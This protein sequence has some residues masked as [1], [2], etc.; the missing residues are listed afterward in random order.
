ME[1]SRTKPLLID[2]ES[3]YVSDDCLNWVSQKHI[4]TSSHK[5]VLP[6][7][8]SKTS[9]PRF[10]Q[11]YALILILTFQSIEAFSSYFVSKHKHQS[12]NI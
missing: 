6:S 10:H 5:D 2:G 12:A 4:L 3:A 1:A 9:S 11:N 8:H 7:S